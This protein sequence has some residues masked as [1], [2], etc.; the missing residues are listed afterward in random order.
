METLLEEMLTLARQ[1]Q[2]IES[3]APVEL[4]APARAAWEVVDTGDADLVVGASTRIRADRSRL[5]QV[6]ENLFRNAIDHGPSGVTVRVELIETGPDS[7]ADVDGFAVVDDGPGIPPD[8]RETIFEVGETTSRD[9]TGLGLAIV[10]NI[11]EA[12]GW[13]I[14]SVERGGAEGARFEVRGVTPAPAP[15]EGES[16]EEASSVSSSTA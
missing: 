10:E 1:G 7:P 8:K 13:T 5:Q 11:A 14:E 9:G 15:G 4:A 2:T 16:P 12:H 6:F 3:T